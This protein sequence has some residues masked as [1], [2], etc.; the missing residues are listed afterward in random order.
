MTNFNRSSLHYVSNDSN[1]FL[2]LAIITVQASAHAI[3]SCNSL[4]IVKLFCLKAFFPRRTLVAISWRWQDA[5]SFKHCWPEYVNVLLVAISFQF[6]FKFVR[7]RAN[8]HCFFVVFFL[9]N[10]HYV[11][12]VQNVFSNS[13]F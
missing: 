6:G 5:S 12:L 7:F 10:L 3:W 2:S 8:Y 11:Y 13:L 4:H 9:V 1:F